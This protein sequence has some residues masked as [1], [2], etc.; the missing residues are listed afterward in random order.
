MRKRYAEMT[1]ETEGRVGV[2]GGG[3]RRRRVVWGVDNG[4]KGCLRSF[5]KLEKKS[6]GKK[7]IPV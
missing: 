4:V 5:Q 3:G 6:V 1:G 7:S 2:E